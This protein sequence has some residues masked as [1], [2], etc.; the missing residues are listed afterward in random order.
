MK[1]FLC[2]PDWQKL[3][4]VNTFTTGRNWEHCYFSAHSSLSIYLFLP[5]T[6]IKWMWTLLLTFICNSPPLL[7]LPQLFQKRPNLIPIHSFFFFCSLTFPSSHQ[8]FQHLKCS[9]SI[10]PAGSSSE[11]SHW[12]S[13]FQYP[14]GGI[15]Y[16]HVN[17]FPVLPIYLLPLVFSLWS[18][19]LWVYSSHALSPQRPLTGF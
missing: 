8:S 7:P 10:S 6:H 3:K 17:A 13:C 16:A 2:L 9:Y 1:Y 5:C 19:P 4:V 15:H 11:L 14:P 18:L 12:A